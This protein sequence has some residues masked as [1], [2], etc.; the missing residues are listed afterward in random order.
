MGKA[1]VAPYHV[2]IRSYGFDLA[3][4]RLKTES[5]SQSYGIFRE[6][7]SSPDPGDSKNIH[8]SDPAR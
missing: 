7:L 6:D 1:R 8:G 3:V 4:R 2:V 5:R